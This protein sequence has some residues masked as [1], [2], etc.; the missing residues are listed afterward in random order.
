MDYLNSLLKYYLGNIISFKNLCSTES[1]SDQMEVS[2][3]ALLYFMSSIE[4]EKSIKL[5]HEHV[6]KILPGLF[7]AF[8]NDEA[9]DAHGRELVL[10]ILYYCLRTVSWADGID[11]DLVD[12]CLQDTFNSWMS[13]FVQIIQTNPRSFFDIKKNAL[14]CLTVIFRDFINY[15]RDCL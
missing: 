2:I 3:K 1:S 15:S 7:S 8:T 11:N 6:P 10:D 5:F 14:K 12:A 13:L 4:D 9:V